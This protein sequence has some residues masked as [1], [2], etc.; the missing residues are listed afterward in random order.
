MPDNLSTR[1]SLGFLTGNL[2]LQVIGSANTQIIASKSYAASSGGIF[3]QIA[4]SLTGESVYAEWLPNQPLQIYHGTLKTGG[5]GNLL[6]Y[7]IFFN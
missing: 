7:T 2:K 5:T 4:S 3:L 1:G 6:Y